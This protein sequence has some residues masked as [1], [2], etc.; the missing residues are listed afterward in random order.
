MLGLWREMVATTFATSGDLVPEASDC[1]LSKLA[2]G[3]VEG[4]IAPIH[5]LKNLPEMLKVEVAVCT[6]HQ[7]VI[8]EGM[9]KGTSWK[10]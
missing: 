8:R 10:L 3:D 9:Q 2:L 7:I 1:W 5:D 4:K 6:A